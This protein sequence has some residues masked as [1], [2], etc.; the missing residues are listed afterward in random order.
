MIGH[1][2]IG[3]KEG[4]SPIGLSWALDPTCGWGNYG[5]QIC[6]H[7][8]QSN[9]TAI[10]LGG[11]LEDR[12][13]K[14]QQTLLTS[15]INI[16][17][18]IQAAR[19]EKS[20]GLL[21]F[22]FPVLHAMDHRMAAS[23]NFRGET[24]IGLIFFEGSRLSAEAIE[25]AK[26]FEFIV[27][28]SNWNAQVMR[29]QGIENVETIVQGIDP[30]LCHP[31]PRSGL[32]GDRFV[33]FSGGKLEHR[34]GQDIVVAAFRAFCREHP[35]AL[36]VCSWHNHWPRLMQSIGQAGHVSGPPPADQNGK[37]YIQQWLE[38]NGIPR[39]NVL[40]MGLVPNHMMAGIM[41]EADVAVFP[42]RAEGG[43]NLVAMECMASGVPSIIAANTGQLDLID[44]SADGQHCLILEDQSP[45]ESSP[46]FSGTEGWGESD[47]VELLDKLEYA[48]QN[49][50]KL[51]QIGAS[52]AQFMQKWTW[53]NQI[54]A[55][56]DSLSKIG[57]LVG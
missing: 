45:V 55:L 16:S 14:L 4:T 2:K 11:A 40:D 20:L 42:N 30:T 32:F 41:R 35:D 25:S 10:P 44:Q 49:R 53:Q 34:K 7:S 27:A 39:Q 28:G 52:A 24:N 31:A 36:L 5:T 26:Q 50:D 57:C 9:L 18:K 22:D 13:T 38:S 54:H 37:I 51:P 17:R 21:K 48:Y 47:P 33:V 46:G 23:Q 6:L 43:T 19:A 8:A 12:L 1:I 29:E 15:N 3:V 56:N